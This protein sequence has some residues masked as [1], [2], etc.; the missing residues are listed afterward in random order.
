MAVYAADLRV[1]D[2]AFG[3]VDDVTPQ[4]LGQVPHSGQSVVS[5][6]APSI[7]CISLRK[8][9]GHDRYATGRPCDQTRS[10]GERPRAPAGEF[11]ILH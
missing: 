9:G 7:T 8:C 6:D 10:R 2:G 3:A 1:L 4:H 11:A 5:M